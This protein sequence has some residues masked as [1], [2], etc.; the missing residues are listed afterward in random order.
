MASIICSNTR[1]LPTLFV[2][3]ASTISIMSISSI[4]ASPARNVIMGSSALSSKYQWQARPRIRSIRTQAALPLSMI[5]NSCKTRFVSRQSGPC[6]RTTPRPQRL[7]AVYHSIRNR[8]RASSGVVYEGTCSSR[9]ALPRFMPVGAFMGLCSAG[10]RQDIEREQLRQLR[11]I[12][13]SP[14]DC[15]RPQ[16]RP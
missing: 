10:S 2:L 11:L 5:C 14:T 3:V 6:F 12:S 13:L 15:S 7:E 8:T 1:D 16:P 4:A 9:R